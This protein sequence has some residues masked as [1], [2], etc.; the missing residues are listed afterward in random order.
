MLSFHTRLA[1]FNPPI[2]PNCLTRMAFVRGAPE[3]AGFTQRAFKCSVCGYAETDIVKIGPAFRTTD[4]KRPK[5][6]R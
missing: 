4:I 2:C 3:Q 1:K 6:A 5:V